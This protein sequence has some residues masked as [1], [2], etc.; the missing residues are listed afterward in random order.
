[1]IVAAPLF[2]VATYS[3]DDDDEE[4]IRWAYQDAKSALLSEEPNAV[5]CFQRVLAIEGKKG[6][7]TVWGLKALRGLVVASIQAVSQYS[8]P[9]LRDLSAFQKCPEM[10]FQV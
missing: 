6:T 9:W 2:Q 3:S 7:K 5:A 10:P 8:K 1:M 4:T